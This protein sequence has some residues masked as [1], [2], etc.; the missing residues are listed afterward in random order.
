MT[1]RTTIT[2]CLVP[3]IYDLLEIKYLKEETPL[4]FSDFV[5]LQLQNAAK[6]AGHLNH[7]PDRMFTDICPVNVAVSEDSWLIDVAT[8]EI[9]A[10][11]LTQLDDFKASNITANSLVGFF[12]PILYRWQEVAH[13]P[14]LFNEW[15]SFRENELISIRTIVENRLFRRNWL[16]KLLF[17]V[18][19]ALAWPFSLKALNINAKL[20][21]QVSTSNTTAMLMHHLNFV[22]LHFFII[23]GL[24]AYL[25]VLITKS[26]APQ[27]SRKIKQIQ[28]VQLIFFVGLFVFG[29]LFSQF[30]TRQ[31]LIATVFGIFQFAIVVNLFI[32][33]LLI[34]WS[35]ISPIDHL[36]PSI[37]Q[38]SQNKAIN[39]V[40]KS[41]SNFNDP[42]INLAGC[43]ISIQENAHLGYSGINNIKLSYQKIV[44]SS[45][46]TINY[47]Y[48]K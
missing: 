5:L 40:L 30:T 8:E 16:M 6:K 33:S 20:I 44:I 3:D 31:I 45:N 46:K 39:I 4:T 34:L 32:I 27:K 24:L 23:I 1:N 12:L 7:H 17:L 28:Y 43:Q 37:W 14:K 26:F 25:T 2:L 47:L 36:S 13:G 15:Q 29:N 11:L 21:N 22:P 19:T 41:T 42:I 35:F 18:L 10:L 9:N 48:E 38:L